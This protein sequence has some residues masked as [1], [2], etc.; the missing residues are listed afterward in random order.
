VIDGA[1]M[2]YA[3]AMLSRRRFLAGSAAGVV[4]LGC[5]NART[6]QART[7]V[8][9]VPALP[10]RDGAGVALRRSIGSRALDLLDPF[11]LLDEIHSSDPADYVAGFPRHP[12]RGFETVS[13]V[14]RGGFA[15]RDSMGNHGLIA[16]GGAQWMTAGHGIVHAEMPQ[17]TGG[18]ELWGLQLWVNLPAAR[19]MIRP[20]YQDLGAAAVPE[21][22]VADARVRLVAG[23]L[24]KA[25]GPVDGID[26]RPTMLD[27]TLA[28]RAQFLHELPGGDT[29]FVYVLD[30]TVAIAGTVVEAGSLAVLSPGTSIAATSDRGGRFLLVAGTPLRE[31]V[32]RRGPFVMTTDAE[33]DQA[34]ADYQ[35]GHLTDDV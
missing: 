21:L 18:P 6:V 26:I 2:R 15:H 3:R 28:P 10:G 12:H 22:D 20:R 23:T 27:A 31:P 29:A 7:V 19:K 16:D 9:V 4:L 17:Q 25:R 8:A 14:L 11:L 34:I 32:A 1:R 5:Q 30:G 35:S 24:G 33:L 13:Y